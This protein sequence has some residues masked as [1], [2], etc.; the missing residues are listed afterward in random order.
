MV[1]AGE[2]WARLGNWQ[3]VETG[4]FEQ[5]YDR[6]REKNGKGMRW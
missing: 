4:E 5:R 3:E 2:Q 1:D 6:G